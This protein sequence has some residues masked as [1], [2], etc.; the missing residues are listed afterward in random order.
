MVSKFPTLEEIKLA[1]GTNEILDEYAEYRT[2]SCFIRP[3]ARMLQVTL[4]PEAMFRGVIELRTCWSVLARATGS[5][6]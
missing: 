2:P 4:P 6:R 3:Q 1:V 5:E